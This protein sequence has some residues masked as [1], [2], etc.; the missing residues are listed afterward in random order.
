MHCKAQ[1]CTKCTKMHRCTMQCKKHI[2]SLCISG[3]ISCIYPPDSE[4]SKGGLCRGLIPPPRS[5][6]IKSTC[7]SP[8]IILYRRSSSTKSYSPYSKV[9]FTAGPYS[10]SLCHQHWEMLQSPASHHPYTGH[11]FQCMYNLGLFILFL[12]FWSLF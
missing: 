12:L 1:M 2:T 5:Q 7:I 10:N 9:Q 4:P 6:C 3:H 11:I 8:C